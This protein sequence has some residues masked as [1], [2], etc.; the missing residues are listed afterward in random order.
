VT[1]FLFFGAVPFLSSVSLLAQVTQGQLIYASSSGRTVSLPLVDGGHPAF[2]TIQ[3]QQG[4]AE[5]LRLFVLSHAGPERMVAPEASVLKAKSPKT[6]RVTH[7]GDRTLKAN[8]EATFWCYTPGLALPS[9][10]KMLNIQWTLQRA[11]LPPKML[12]VN[13]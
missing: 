2:L 11:D 10:F 8:A 12:V 9:S 5:K 6:W 4:D 13:P 7:K 1:R 3:A